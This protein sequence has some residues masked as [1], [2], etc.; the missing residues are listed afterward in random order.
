MARRAGRSVLFLKADGHAAGVAVQ[1]FPMGKVGDAALHL[2]Q[3]LGGV[4]DKAGFLDKIVHAQGAGKPD[5]SK[6]WN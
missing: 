2:F 4:V 6:D 5:P 3:R 1:P